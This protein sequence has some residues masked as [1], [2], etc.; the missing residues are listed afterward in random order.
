MQQKKRQ[1]PGVRMLRSQRCVVIARETIAAQIPSSI[2]CP[3]AMQPS[4]MCAHSNRE[5]NDA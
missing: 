5:M 2:Y 4:E 3:A 1:I